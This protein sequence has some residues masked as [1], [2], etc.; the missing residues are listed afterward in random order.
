MVILITSLILNIINFVV[1]LNWLG[2]GSIGIW[3]RSLNPF[4]Y[5]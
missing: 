4:Y 2:F 5:N 3:G 1:L